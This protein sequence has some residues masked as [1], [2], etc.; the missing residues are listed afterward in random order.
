MLCA[1]GQKLQAQIEDICFSYPNYMHWYDAHPVELFPL[2]LTGSYIYYSSWSDGIGW[3]DTLCKKNIIVHPYN[4]H[5]P[6][7][8]D[9]CKIYGLAGLLSGVCDATSGLYDHQKMMYPYYHGFPFDVSVESYIFEVTEG[10]SLLRLVKKQVFKLAKGQYPDKGMHLS[11]T[12]GVV[13]PVYEFYFDTPVTVKGTFF[14]ALF[15]DASDSVEHHKIL[16]GYSPS[17]LISFANHRDTLGNYTPG[18]SVSIGDERIVTGLGGLIKGDDGKYR[19]IRIDHFN[20][21]ELVVPD[22][23]E[24]VWYKYNHPAIFPII[25]LHN[26]AVDEVSEAGDG[27]EVSPN[28]SRGCAMVHSM[29]AIRSVEV[30]DMSGRVVLRKQVNGDLHTVEMSASLPRGCYVVR[31]VTVQGTAVKKLVVE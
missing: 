27:V 7:R 2:E 20:R 18:Y 31:V 14:V 15:G 26:N 19:E 30:C 28:P 23:R 5:T 24:Q 10:D 13:A 4:F 3:Q 9:S 21:D 12:G 1:N 8:V 25:S 16:F 22:M 29:R 6:S 17:L 11:D